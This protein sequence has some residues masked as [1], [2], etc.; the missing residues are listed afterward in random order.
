MCWACRCWACSIACALSLTFC[1][2]CAFGTVVLCP[3]FAYY[4]LT[5][6]TSPSRWSCSHSFDLPLKS[7]V[8]SVKYI[9][10]RTFLVYVVWACADFSVQC[11]LR[12]RQPSV[13]SWWDCCLKLL[14]CSW[15]ISCPAWPVAVMQVTGWQGF[16]L[17]FLQECKTAASFMSL[18]CISSIFF[19][20]F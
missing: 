11:V 8:Q 4:F 13:D 15:V 1:Q 10:C 9:Q 14:Y 5:K 2:A 18:L 19:F 16:S 12:C 7:F 20:L 3:S 17:Y 6:R